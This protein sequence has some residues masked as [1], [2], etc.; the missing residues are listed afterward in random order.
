MRK[1]ERALDA[2]EG[3][4]KKFTSVIDFTRLNYLWS[5]VVILSQTPSAL[6]DY[7]MM[8]PNVNNLYML[9]D[10]S[11]YADTVFPTMARFHSFLESLQDFDLISIEEYYVIKP[12]GQEMFAPSMD[13]SAEP[14]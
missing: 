3:I 8:H 13:P 1:S 12:L 7:L 10:G 9:K 2:A 11:F 4:V 14:P 5:H 6:K